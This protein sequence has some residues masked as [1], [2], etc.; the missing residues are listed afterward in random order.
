MSVEFT[1]DDIILPSRELT[2]VARAVFLDGVQVME[3]N[4][5][6]D[7]PDPKKYHTARHVG[8]VV[9]NAYLIG[10]AVGFSEGH[11]VTLIAAASYHDA[12]FVLGQKGENERKSGEF[13][14][15][16][17]H[18][19]GNIFQ[20]RDF[21]RV[22]R[23][24]NATVTDKTADNLVQHPLTW[25]DMAL[26]DADLGDLSAETPIFWESASLESQERD[27]TPYADPSY[28]HM[29]EFQAALLA[30]NRPYLRQTSDVLPF[31]AQNLEYIK[32]QQRQAA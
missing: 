4:H 14:V 24:I 26:C 30:N 15:E 18:S 25:L 28:R 19:I 10:N 31:R 2:E 7:S 13:A 27:G 9:G 21:E 11:L 23:M 8:R 32:D 16:R 1:A 29:L 17:M 6:P 20:G 12:I 5:G 3:V 22:V